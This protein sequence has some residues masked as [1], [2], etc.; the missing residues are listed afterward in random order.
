MVRYKG[1]GVYGAVAVGRISVF[2][3]RDVEV[4]RVRVEDTGA[5]LARLVEAKKK[6]ASQLQQIY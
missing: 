4:K 5:E 6:A 1:K 3:R 2:R